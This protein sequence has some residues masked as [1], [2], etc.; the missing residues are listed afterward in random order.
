MGKSFKRSK[1]EEIRFDGGIFMYKEFTSTNPS[2]EEMEDFF[3]IPKEH[4]PKDRPYIWFMA[5]KSRD[6][7]LSFKEFDYKN[8]AI[9]LSGP[10]IALA[11]LREVTPIAAGSLLDFRF[12]QY[13]WAVADAVIGG[14]GIIRAEPKNSWTVSLKDLI[15]YRTNVL[16]KNKNPIQV[17]LTAKGLER[18]LLTSPIFNSK[19]IT[20]IIATSKEGADAMGDYIGSISSKVEVFGDKRVD[21]NKMLLRLRQHYGVRLVD[22]QGGGKIANEFRRLGLIDEARIT[23][24]PVSIGS[25]NSR[26]ETRPGLFEGEGSSPDNVVLHDNIALGKYGSYF[27]IRDRL[28]YSLLK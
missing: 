22:F 15:E 18:D 17:V 5:V 16:K 20:S 13:G 28:V 23:D 9:G 27:F 24:S 26:G 3:S 14:S 10:G 2:I 21:I 4:I 6:G 8:P 25:L 12:L 19:D 11:H 1:R 7:R